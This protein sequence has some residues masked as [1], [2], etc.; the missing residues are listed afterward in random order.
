MASPNYLAVLVAAIAIFMLGG[1]WYSKLLFARKW[2]ELQG[3]TIDGMKE[4]G[5]GASPF[6][7]VQVFICGFLTAW[8]LALLMH[9]WN[10]I[11]VMG[12]I[13]LAALCWLGFAG[14]TLYG[15]YLF[16]SRPK[17]LWAIDSLY[18]LASMLL[19][20]AILGAWH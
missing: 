20:G 15:S 5:Q 4:A 19:A 6:M 18:N 1:L 16:S 10:V 3:K 2:V 11:T 9:H 14:A 17:A 13:H 7:F 8:V 12:G